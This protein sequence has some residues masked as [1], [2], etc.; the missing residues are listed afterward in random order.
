MS[1]CATLW[2]GIA[3]SI[4]MFDD[5]VAGPILALG[6]AILGPQLGIPLA[7]VVFTVLVAGLVG[8]ALGAS[9]QVDAATQAR[10]DGM[11]DRASRRRF[12]GRFVRQVGDDHPVATAIVAMIVSPVFA[13]L[14]ARLVHPEQRLHRTAGIAVMAYG[15]AFSVVYATGGSVIAS[16]A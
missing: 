9:R 12:V 6:G 11:V 4:T 10:I 13:V 2:P 3:L 14:L 15:L 8:S 1:R 7:I 16:L 5:L